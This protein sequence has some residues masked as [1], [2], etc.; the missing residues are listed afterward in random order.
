MMIITVPLAFPITP[1]KT[2][3]INV[4]IVLK[5]FINLVTMLYPSSFR[6]NLIVLDKPEQLKNYIDE[7][8]I[9]EE[10]GGKLKVDYY[11]WIADTFW[12]NTN[13]KYFINNNNNK[14]TDCNS[15]S[16]SSLNGI[17]NGK[18]ETL[19]IPESFKKFVKEKYMELVESWRNDGK[20]HNKK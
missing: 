15:T 8:Y 5:T 16:T 14:I 17:E 9:L 11:D 10:Y 20:K 13:S 2:I 3:L 6:D 4:P 7:K 18:V 1:G 19:E 12:W